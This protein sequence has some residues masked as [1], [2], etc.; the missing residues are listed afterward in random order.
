[1]RNSSASRPRPIS[2]LTRSQPQY[3]LTGEATATRPHWSH[4][5]WLLPDSIIIPL[6]QP[7]GKASLS[8]PIFWDMF[9]VGLGVGVQGLIVAVRLAGRERDTFSWLS[10]VRGWE[11]GTMD[12]G[13]G[14][15]STMNITSF[16][17][18]CNNNEH[19]SIDLTSHQNTE[20]YHENWKERVIHS[21]RV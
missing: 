14:D 18:I 13:H 17:R 7:Q 8:L 21:W 11:I 12:S 5:G 19:Q 20:G 2:H 9:D 10:F 6:Y 4:V 1:M 15:Y 16:S 3:Q